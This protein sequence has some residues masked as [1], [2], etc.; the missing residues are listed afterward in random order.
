MV[1]VYLGPLWERRLGYVES[2]PGRKEVL[3]KIGKEAPV[4]NHLHG[5][6]LVKVR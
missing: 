5:I 4:V 2:P 3:I 1:A 6:L